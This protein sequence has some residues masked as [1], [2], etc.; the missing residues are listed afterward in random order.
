MQPAIP[1]VKPHPV[2]APILAA[3]DQFELLLK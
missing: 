3:G 1:V 2:F